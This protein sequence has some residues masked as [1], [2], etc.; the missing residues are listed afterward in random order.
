MRVYILFWAKLEYFTPYCRNS[1]PSWASCKT[2]SKNKENS[3]LKCTTKHIFFYPKSMNTFALKDAGCSYMKCHLLYLPNL[4]D[5]VP[6]LYHLPLSLTIL[7]WCYSTYQSLVFLLSLLLSFLPGSFPLCFY[8]VS[9]LLKLLRQYCRG[10]FIS[11]KS[12]TT[13]HDSNDEAIQPEWDPCFMTHYS[14]RSGSQVWYTWSL[15]SFNRFWNPL[16]QT[17]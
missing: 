14:Q 6:T 15:N 1:R 17:R 11:P 5:T 8:K 2:P 13:K 3:W 4:S 10:Q 16:V 9:L 12:L 7:G